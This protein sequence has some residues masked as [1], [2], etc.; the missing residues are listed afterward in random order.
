MKKLLNISVPQFLLSKKGCTMTMGAETGQRHGSVPG[1]CKPSTNGSSVIFIYPSHGG[2]ATL[3]KSLKLSKPPETGT[4]AEASLGLWV[5]FNKG[6]RGRASI[7]NSCGIAQ[8]SR[9]SCSGDGGRDAPRTTGLSKNRPVHVL[10][11]LLPSSRRM[12]YWASEVR[13][14]DMVGQKGHCQSKVRSLRVAGWDLHRGPWD[15]Y[16]PCHSKPQLASSDSLLPRR[17]CA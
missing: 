6:I 15:A 2:S 14:E 13:D 8:A 12:A 11:K 17:P 16:W 4:A 9:A 3:G 10:F 5:E 1:Q 7:S